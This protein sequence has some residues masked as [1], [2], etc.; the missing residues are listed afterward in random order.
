MF[1]KLIAVSALMT[2]FS[3]SAV[4]VG[5]VGGGTTGNNDGGLAGVTVGQKF[6]NFGLTAGYAQA[7]LNDGDQNR[8]SLVASYD[9]YKNNYFVVAPKV[10]YA[11]VNQ[12]ANSGSVGLVGLGFEIPVTKSVA[13]TADYAYQ[14]GENSSM[15][16]NII[17]GGVKV[18]F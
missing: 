8:Y 18:K 14:F 10:G 9:I 5:V 12:T 2:A 13:L 1:K 7:W 15:N 16:T 4:E 11:Y 3:A 17:T 6:G